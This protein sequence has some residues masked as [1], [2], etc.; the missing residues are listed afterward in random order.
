MFMNAKATGDAPE[1]T[2]AVIAEAIDAKEYRL[3][4]PTGESARALLNGRAR[5]SDEEWVALGR[6]M[7]DE[8]Y[9]AE[10]NRILG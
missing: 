5:L 4:Y 10:M 8:E 6:T 1:S 2:A 9:I 7:S 3:R